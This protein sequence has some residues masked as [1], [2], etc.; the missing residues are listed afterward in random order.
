MS[1]PLQAHQSSCFDAKACTAIF[2][3][4]AENCGSDYCSYIIYL[5]KPPK[6][7]SITFGGHAND[8]LDIWVLLNRIFVGFG[9]YF[10]LTFLCHQCLNK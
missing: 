6:L 1:L 10:E 3:N 7:F 4:D 9:F 2:Q 8:H 5:E